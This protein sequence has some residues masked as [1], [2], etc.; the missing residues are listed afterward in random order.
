MKITVCALF[1]CILLA[2]G[3]FSLSPRVSMA[4]GVVQHTITPKAFLEDE[5]PD[6]LILTPMREETLSYP[7]TGLVTVIIQLD[8]APLAVSIQQVMAENLPHL[9][10]LG[11]IRA[12]STQIRQQQQELIGLLMAPP[13]NARLIGTTYITSNTII[14]EIDVTL[15]D[16]I[17]TL[18]GVASVKPDRIGQLDESV[19][20][21][22][23][24]PHF[25]PK[26][27]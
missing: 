23:R 2:S 18:S 11:E 3:L 16:Q 14:V 27:D 8:S 25:G 24:P 4:Q 5:P 13:Y 22:G 12:R 7:S 17:N 1:V 21:P 26:L 9:Q 20:P 15:I 19:S 6:L 10:F